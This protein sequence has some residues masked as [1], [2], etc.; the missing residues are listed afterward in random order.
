MKWFKALKKWATETAT[1]V[2]IKALNKDVSEPVISFIRT[3]NANP[4]RFKVVALTTT[5]MGDLFP[6]HRH[7]DHPMHKFK[8]KDKVTGEEW[9]F[10][11]CVPHDLVY[12]LY[13]GLDTN[14]RVYIAYYN[15]TWIEGSSYLTSD[16]KELIIKTIY[17]W[18]FKRVMK[19]LDYRHRHKLRRE[20]LALIAQE[21]RDAAERERLKGVYNS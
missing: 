20:K 15:K 3:F 4:K 13:C 19:R 18:H 17:D 8:F 6:I 16:E 5:K 21:K 11:S 2:E 1:E 9:S 7:S 14:R 12:D 10:S